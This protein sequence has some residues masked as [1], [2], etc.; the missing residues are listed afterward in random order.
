M[1][2]F[3]PKSISQA[4]FFI[5]IEHSLN[6]HFSYVSEATSIYAAVRGEFVIIKCAH[7]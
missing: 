4:A 3:E 1:E 7:Y 6:L 2:A 5:F